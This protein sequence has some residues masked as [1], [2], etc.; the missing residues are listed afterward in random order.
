MAD[1]LSSTRRPATTAARRTRSTRSAGSTHSSAT[2]TARRRCPRPRA[3]PAGPRP[4]PAGRRPAWA[5][6]TWD[7]L[8]Y[9][10]HHLG[11]HAEAA[12]C[13][14]DALVLYRDLGDRYNEADTL[15]HLGDTHLP[16]GDG[17]VARAA[18]HRAL[19]ILSD[20]GHPDA[21]DVTAKLTG[22][23]GSDHAMRREGY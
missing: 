11:R 5:A 9:A 17:A 16:A 12:E 1:H 18:W 4:V 8:G 13:Y 15:S 21:A 2:L 14:Q 19:A 20:L 10:Y 3:L 23:D 6:N 7:S 22:L